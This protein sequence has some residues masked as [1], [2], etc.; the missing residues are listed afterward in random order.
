MYAKPDPKKAAFNARKR[1]AEQRR[2]REIE[3]C[4]RQHK[5]TQVRHA[6][7][8]IEADLRHHLGIDV[9]VRLVSADNLCAAA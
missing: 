7:A 4:Y 6:Q 3:T 9:T 1:E 8:M 2:Q 5:P